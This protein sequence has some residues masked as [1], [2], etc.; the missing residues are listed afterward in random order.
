MVEGKLTSEG[1]APPRTGRINGIF[2][3][4]PR[5]HVSPAPPAGSH[6]SLGCACACPAPH[7]YPWERQSKVSSDAAQPGHTSQDEVG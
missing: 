7:G 2:V 6:A 3:L 1:W 5:Q 4:P